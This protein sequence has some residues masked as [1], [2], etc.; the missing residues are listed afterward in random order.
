MVFSSSPLGLGWAVGHGPSAEACLPLT[1]VEARFIPTSAYVVRPEPL[2]QGAEGIPSP[3]GAEAESSPEF[4]LSTDRGI[5]ILHNDMSRASQL[6]L[7]NGAST[8]ALFVAESPSLARFQDAC[9][10]Q[11]TKCPESELNQMIL[12]STPDKRTR[13]LHILHPGSNNE[14]KLIILSPFHT[15]QSLENSYY[16]TR[17]SECNN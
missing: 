8:Y 5:V 7:A 1:V 17:G 11:D 16:N 13:T 14:Y 2:P 3:E 4:R 15:T 10:P 6:V 9:L 12:S